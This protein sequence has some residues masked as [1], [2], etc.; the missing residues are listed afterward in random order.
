MSTKENITSEARPAPKPKTLRTLLIVLIILVAI[1]PIGILATAPA[2]G[3]SGIANP[4]FSFWQAL[5]P[6]YG[7]DGTFGLSTNAGYYLA[8]IIGVGVIL[9]VLLTIWK[10]KAKKEARAGA[11]T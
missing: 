5:L 7:T 2:W 3:E 10:F 6:D 8:A 4:A 1:V 11:I 9:G